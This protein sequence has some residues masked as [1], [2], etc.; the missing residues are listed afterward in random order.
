IIKL[1]PD[2]NQLGYVKALGGA[3][4]DSA[5]AL[6]VQGG[7]VYVAGQT[8]SAD[9]PT[10]PGA[11]QP[12]AG[13]GYAF[14]AKLDPAG[15]AP[16]YSTYLLGN[17]NL[18]EIKDIAVDPSGSAYVVGTTRSALSFPATPKAYQSVAHGDRDAFVVK[19]N[20]AGSAYSYA[21]LLGGAAND[22]ASAI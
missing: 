14:L 15:T 20:A 17:Y 12:A 9:F 6:A 22:S 16:V 21:T 18:D 11:L 8:D 19:V 3:G 4:D 2:G 10:T 1:N 7:N 13:Y 5:R